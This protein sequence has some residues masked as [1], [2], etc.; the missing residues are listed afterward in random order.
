[1]RRL[2]FRRVRSSEQRDGD[3]GC[4]NSKDVQTGS[5]KREAVCVDEEAI[6]LYDM[7]GKELQ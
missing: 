5:D 3:R 6:D 2:H 7:Y 4:E 1:M